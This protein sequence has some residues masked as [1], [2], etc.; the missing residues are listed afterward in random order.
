MSK[1]CFV[2]NYFIWKET[3]N[4]QPIRRAYEKYY[5]W[6]LS[7]I[8][9]LREYYFNKNKLQA[10]KIWY[11]DSKQVKKIMFFLFFNQVSCCFNNLNFYKVISGLIEV[12]ESF[13]KK[14]NGSVYLIDN[15]LT[16]ADI[17]LYSYI[18]IIT[19]NFQFTPIYEAIDKF[20]NLA[21]FYENLND[22]YGDSF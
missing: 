15:R 22:I 3:A 11:K 4:Q 1:T 20:T 9:Y 13:D 10:S 6:P 17:L 14:L 18:K 19:H 7:S 21:D 8:L 12:V 2:K 5:P 16:E